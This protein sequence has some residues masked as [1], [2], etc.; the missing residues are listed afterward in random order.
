MNVRDLSALP[1]ADLV[2]EGLQDPERNEESHEASPAD[3][4]PIRVGREGGSPFVAQEGSVT[5]LHFD[6][7]AQAL[8][9]IERG[10]NTDRKDVAEF[11]GRGQV[12]RQRLREYFDARWTR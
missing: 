12:G 2:I 6:L 4:I 9:K 7:Y 11:I 10:H 1:G 5:F 3:F 8:A